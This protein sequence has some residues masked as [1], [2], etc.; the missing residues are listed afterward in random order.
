M[1]FPAF[2]S[3]IKKTSVSPA[4][5]R[6][7]GSGSVKRIVPRRKPNS[8][9]PNRSFKA[10]S[11]MV[12]RSASDPASTRTVWIWVALKSV[13]KFWIFWCW[14]GSV[15]R[16]KRAAPMRLA[17]CMI[18]ATSSSR[19]LVAFQGPG[20][21]LEGRFKFFGDDLVCPEIEEV[22]GIPDVPGPCK[23]MHIGSK[24]AGLYG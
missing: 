13:S 9:M 22:L 5:R 1:I 15:H 12:F 11:P 8:L 23:D 2:S 19:D 16:V 10:S 17:R 3:V 20:E 14:V 7:A 18:L 24:P 6:R 21:D 4:S